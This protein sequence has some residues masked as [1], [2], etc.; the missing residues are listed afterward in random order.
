MSNSPQYFVFEDYIY[1]VILPFI[2]DTKVADHLRRSG[3]VLP[4]SYTSG[5]LGQP[6]YQVT[7]P[8]AGV[9]PFHAF[10][11]LVAPLCYVTDD[12]I[13]LYYIFR[14]LYIRYFANLVAVASHAKSILSLAHQ[15][16]HLLLERDPQLSIH[17]ANIGLVRSISFIICCFIYVDSFF[18]FY[19]LSLLFASPR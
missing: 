16:E 12:Q 8:P 5:R 17:L 4:H 14:E 10:S 3:H 6:E 15:F 13:E 1:Q 19:F 9:L 18:C 2:R 11:M 7:Y